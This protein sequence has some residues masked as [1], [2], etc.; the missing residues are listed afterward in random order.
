MT[1]GEINKLGAR[2]YFEDRGVY[3]NPYPIG[4]PESNEFERGWMQSLKKDGAHLVSESEREAG[5][6]TKIARAAP[7]ATDIA[8][9]APTATDIAAE[10]YRSRKG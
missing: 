8:R 3:R 1:L 10:R 6:Q 2:K 9:A 5:S 4:S 7:T